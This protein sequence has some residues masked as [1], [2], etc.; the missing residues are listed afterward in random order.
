MYGNL[1]EWVLDSHLADGY[2]KV[3]VGAVNPLQLGEARYNRIVRGGHYKITA[4]KCRSASRMNSIPIWKVRDP[5]RPQSLWYLASEIGMEANKFTPA[6][7]IGFRIVRP[8]TTP[9]L[10]TMHQLWNTGP[11]KE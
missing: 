11:G 7:T 6:R 10:K 4:D 1:A 8:T 3:P 2:A 9:S 5:Q